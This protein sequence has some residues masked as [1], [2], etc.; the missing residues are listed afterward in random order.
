MKKTHMRSRIAFLIVL[1]FSLNGGVSVNAIDTTMPEPIILE[2]EA[3]MSEEVGVLGDI[4]VGGS[5]ESE[6]EE[7]SLNYNYWKTRIYGSGMI[8]WIDLEYETVA[9]RLETSLTI[10]RSKVL[11]IPYD[12]TT[13]SDLEINSD[14]VY[15]RWDDG[16]DY[17][18][19]YAS[20]SAYI[21]GNRVSTLSVFG[22]T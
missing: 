1:L 7:G 10:T 16:I 9:A 8:C 21:N 2:D 20:G 12:Q 6:I 17:I 13:L 14:Y 11:G 19:T 22:W 5:G 4:V 3:V 18:A 15:T